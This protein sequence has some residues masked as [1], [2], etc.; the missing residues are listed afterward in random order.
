MDSRKV[1]G[2][3]LLAAGLGL[4][5]VSGIQILEGGGSAGLSIADA[6]ASPAP[7][8][9]DAATASRVPVASPTPSPEPSPTLDADAQVRAF[10]VDLMAAIRAGT[11]ESMGARLNGAVIDRYGVSACEGKLAS[12]A[13][14][15][16]Y[17]ITVKAVHPLATWDYVTDERTTTIPEAWTVDADVT[18]QGQTATRQ[19]HVAPMDGTVSWFTDCGDPLPTP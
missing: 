12:D 17:V 15:P 13:A 11:E 16:T 7:T 10:F 19:L 2:T 5:V 6:S 8:P 3:L 4:A 14:D 9:T 1:A 18:A